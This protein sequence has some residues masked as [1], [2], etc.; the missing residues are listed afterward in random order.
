[1]EHNKIKGIK[2]P[3][4]KSSTRYENIENL[5]IP[6]EVIIYTSQHIGAPAT[7]VVKKADIVKKGQ[8][9]AEANGSC[10][11]NM[12]ASISGKIKEIAVVNKG[13]GTVCEAIIIKKE[14]TQIAD[15]MEPLNEITP[16]SI[17][18]RVFE[19]GIVGMGGAGFPAHIKLDPPKKIDTAI[20]NGC[21]C[22]PYLTADERMMVEEPEK[23]V[24][25]F[26][27][28]KIAVGAEK[29]IIGIEEDKIEAIENMKKVIKSHADGGGHSSI[30]LVILPKIY[31][32]GYEKMLITALTTREVPSG[33][34][35]HD[36]G[37]SI[38]N[39]GTCLA[40]YKAVIQGKPLIEKVLTLAGQAMH[41]SVN[42][43]VPIGMNITDVLGYY[44]IEKYRDYEIYLGGPM[45]GQSLDTINVGILKTT[46]GIVV[47]NSMGADFR[48][49]ACVRCGRCVD[50]CPVKLVPQV[51]NK[52]CDIIVSNGHSAGSRLS[53]GESFAL[54]RLEENGIYD[55]MECGCCSYICPSRIELAAKF[56]AVKNVC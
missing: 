33:G 48:E 40:I 2:I 19:A 21:E 9:I 23:V 52:F 20:L 31:P 50:V 41:S 13:N 34:L 44:H 15:F 26:T 4:Y 24:E 56:K 51:L 12:H 46:S 1:M 10:S 5:P 7:P 39:V 17:R 54:S 35:P 42:I 8:L 38:C 49:R 45:M 53:A 30:K 18:K 16:Q 43:K 3:S 22:E 37:V 47:T 29:G 25:G 36:I 11:I 55:C 6:D 14:G 32:Q 28:A 27:F